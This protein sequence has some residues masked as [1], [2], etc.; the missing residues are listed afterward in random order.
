VKIFKIYILLLILLIPEFLFSQVYSKLKILNIT[1][2]TIKFLACSGL[3][4]EETYYNK[5]DNSMELIVDEKQY[6]LIKKKGIQYIEVIDDVVRWFLN[7]NNQSKQVF[8]KTKS[9]LPKGFIYGSMG[10]YPKINEFISM[11]D[12]MAILYTDFVKSKESIGK[13]Y[14][15]RDIYLIKISNYKINKEKDKILFTGLHHAREGASLTSLL[16]YM[17]YI[18][19]NYERD[20]LIKFL[21][22][23]KEFYFIPMLNPDGY[24]YN[25][26]TNPDGGGMWRKNRTPYGNEFGVDLNR[27]YGYMWGYDEVGSSSQPSYI[28]YRGPEPFSENETKAIKKLCESNSFVSAI[29]YHTY[30]NLIVYPWGYTNL[31]PPDVNWYRYISSKIVKKINYKYGNAYETVG[32]KT[33]G[34]SDDWLY[35]DNKSKNKIFAFSPELGLSTDYFWAT[36]DRIEPIAEEAMCINN[37][38]CLYSGAYIDSVCIKGENFICSNDTS[39][40][41][42]QLMNG[43][44]REVDSCIIQISTTDTN[45][46]L[47]NNKL[48]VNHIKAFDVSDTVFYRI[49]FKKNTPFGYTAKYKLMLNY[50]GLPYQKD[51]SIMK[52]NDKPVNYES[53]DITQENNKILLKWT[54]NYEMRHNGFFIDK[55]SNNQNYLQIGYVPSKGELG[56]L[57]TFLDFPKEAGYYTYRIRTYDNNEPKYTPEKNI[58]FKLYPYRYSLFQNYP[59][60]SNPETT[61]SFYLPYRT[62]LELS[63]YNVLGKKIK[64]IVD[65][66]YEEGLHNVKVNLSDLPSQVYFYELKTNDYREVKKLILV[67]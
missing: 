7:K 43:G 64:T 14:E 8:Y 32:Y 65:N 28:T 44:L 51:L 25:Q 20:S 50:N 58:Y 33:N 6:E 18:L 27:N 11:L 56:G 37:F 53:F 59:N 48:M 38:I 39:I 46:I 57:Y 29:N 10:G 34:D 26:L 42:I 3:P 55:K 66:Y 30:G 5:F 61:I 36:I 12:T 40:V 9:E 45:L 62:K 13:T 16:Y 1:D 47:I 17:F 2:E 15:G 19:E 52:I 4:L 67:K 54:T 23:N 60:P 35:G 22:D 31:Q 21:L 49:S 41:A 63:I 24:A